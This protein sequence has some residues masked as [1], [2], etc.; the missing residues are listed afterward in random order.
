MPTRPPVHRPS[1]LPP[2]GQRQ[3]AAERDR[4]SAASRGYG[5]DWRRVRALVLAEEPLCRFCLE[6]GLYVPA[7]HVDH[8]VPFAGAPELRLDRT[9]LR[10]LCEQCHQARTSREGGLARPR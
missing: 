4:G 9:N 5:S 1:Y 2:A 6:R 10:P 7:E 8:I 3:R